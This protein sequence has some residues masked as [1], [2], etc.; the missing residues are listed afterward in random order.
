[1]KLRYHIATI[2]FCT[3]LLNPEAAPSIPVGVLLLGEAKG[4]AVALLAVS[5]NLPLPD[6][7]P[8]V[9]RE[10]AEQFPQ[11]VQAQLEEIL[12]SDARTSIDEIMKVF[13]DSLRNSFFVSDLQLNQVVEIPVLKSEVLQ[14]NW[15]YEPTHAAAASIVSTFEKPWW[16]DYRYRPWRLPPRDSGT[17]L[18]GR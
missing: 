5:R 18:S 15:L 13:E 14:D 7:C 12:R 8:P 3:D 10:I 2:S 9:V 4:L 11:L 16:M 1:M 6:S 17:S